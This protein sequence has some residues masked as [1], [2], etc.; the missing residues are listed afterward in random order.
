VIVQIASE[1][2]MVGRDR[3]GVFAFRDTGRSPRR[4]LFRDPAPA[5]ADA[6]ASQPSL[7]AVGGG[8]KRCWGVSSCCGCQFIC[9]PN[10]PRVRLLI[11][12]E[13]VVNPLNVPYVARGL[14]S[15]SSRHPSSPAFRHRHSRLKF[16]L[17][18]HIT[19]PEPQSRC[20]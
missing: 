10:S 13:D 19:G 9:C 2:G 18:P 12:P 20:R 4:S 16:P 14:P 5:Q 15:A 1:S 8:Q 11:A 7:A 6:C 17:S 3:Q